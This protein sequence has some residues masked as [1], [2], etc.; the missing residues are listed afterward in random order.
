MI[1]PSGGDE[2]PSGDLVW[3]KLVTG[4]ALCVHMLT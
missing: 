4:L 3:Q 1:T 2:R